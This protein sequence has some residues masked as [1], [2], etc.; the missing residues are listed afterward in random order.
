MVELQKAKEPIELNPLE[1]I[2][3]GVSEYFLFQNQ[4]EH[5]RKYLVT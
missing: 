3:C 4:K 1:G 2:M 5:P